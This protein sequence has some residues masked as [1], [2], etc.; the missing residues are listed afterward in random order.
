MAMR[1][2]AMQQQI[3]Q[4]GA[5][6]AELKQAIESLCHQESEPTVQEPPL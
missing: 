5:T 6:Q 3:D 4:E 2:Q 1:A